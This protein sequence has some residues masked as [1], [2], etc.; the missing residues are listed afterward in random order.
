MHALV[1]SY[2]AIIEQLIL[3]AGLNSRSN[4][5]CLKILLALSS[6]NLINRGYSLSLSLSSTAGPSNGAVFCKQDKTRK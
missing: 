6:H 4:R 5:T 3:S 1:W 2:K